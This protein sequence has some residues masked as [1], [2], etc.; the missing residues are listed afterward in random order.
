MASAHEQ[1]PLKTLRLLVHAASTLFGR[2]GSLEVT[3]QH[4]EAFV[5]ISGTDSVPQVPQHPLYTAFSLLA[6]ISIKACRQICRFWLVEI[7]KK[8]FACG[9]AVHE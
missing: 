2:R 8:V 9:E 7:G 4:P 1:R 3:V 6:H 5:S